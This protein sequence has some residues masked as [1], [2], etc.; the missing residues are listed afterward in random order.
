[1]EMLGGCVNAH[2]Q[3]KSTPRGTFTVRGGCISWRRA[4]ALFLYTTVEHLVLIYCFLYVL[5][6]SIIKGFSHTTAIVYV[7]CN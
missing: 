4:N 3:K 7:N 5:C 1:M 2:Q 6:S